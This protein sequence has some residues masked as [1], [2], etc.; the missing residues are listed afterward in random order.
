M[1]QEYYDKLETR[2]SADRERDLCGRLPG[3]IALAMR[4]PGWAAQLVGIDAQAVTSREALGRLPVLRKSDLAARQQ[5]HP[6]LGGFNVTAP[7]RMRRLL[8]SPGPI[9]EPEG[10]GA[11][12]WGTARALF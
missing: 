10:A 11:D 2:D 7:G 9:F 5:A 1:S 3:L 12:Y 6:P 4:A 8:M